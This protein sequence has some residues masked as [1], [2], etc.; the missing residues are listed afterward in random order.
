MLMKKMYCLDV[1]DDYSRFTW[2]FFLASKDETSAILKTFIIGTKNLVDHK[3]E[4][5]N[6]ACHVQNRVL[7][8]KPHNKTPHEIFHGRTLALSFMRPFECPV[9]I[10]NTKD[11]L[12][13]FDGKADEGFF[14]GYFVNSKA[15]TIFNNRTRTVEEN[16]HIRFSKNTHNIIG[17]RPNWLFDNDALTKSMNNKPFV[18]R[19]QSNGNAGTKACDDVD[20]GFLPLTDDGKN[21]DEDPRHESECK[22]QEKEHNVNSTNNV[23]VAG[24]NEVNIMDVKSA[25][26]YGKIEEEVYVCQPLGFEDPNFPDKVY[27]VEKVLYELHQA[28]KECQ[29]KYVAETLKK[30]GFSEVKNVSTPMETQKPLL[31]DEDGEKADVH[32]YLKGQP[33]FGLWYLKDSPFDLVAYPDNDYDGESLDKKST[34]GGC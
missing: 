21:V 7:A 20:D 4:A 14:V 8:V 12:G 1:T 22:D 28:P 27:K 17:S 24:T 5:A 3:A 6:T 30:Y 15:F 34:T 33:K 2:V 23:N 31:K 19:N 9:T 18:A 25:F 32:M 13:K 16:L 29:D 10:L 11:H 26:L